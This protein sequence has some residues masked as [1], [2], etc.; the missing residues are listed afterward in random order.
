MFERVF[1]HD[2]VKSVL[3]KMVASDRLPHGVCFHGPSGIGKRLMAAEL[4]KAMLCENR[5]GCGE[6]RH[7]KKL[8]SGNHPDFTLCEPAGQDIKVDQIREIA[9]NLH[10]RP[11]EGR[12]RMVVLD[13][14]ERLRE[15]AANAFL[16]SLEEPPEYVYF[17]LVCSDLKA[18]L[19]TILSRCQKIGFQSL[20]VNDKVNIL[21]ERFDKDEASAQRLARISFDRLETEDEAYAQFEQDLKAVLSFLQQ[22][23]A[24][25]HALDVLSEIAR[26]KQVFPRFKIHFLAVVREMI[27]LAYGQK[28]DPLF[29]SV[30]GVMKTMAQQARPEAWREMFEQMLWLEGQRRRN[31]NQGLWFNALSVSGLGLLEASE[32]QTAARR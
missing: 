28:G 8:A 13:Q 10:F 19:P 21:K 5:T 24:E 4:A 16:K 18:L 6:C 27:R 3:E 1:G 25:G 14:V 29:E 26:D 31:L 20:N 9:E 12:V 11:F 22:M 32:R 2:R 17:I 15:G 23:L 30:S 7:C